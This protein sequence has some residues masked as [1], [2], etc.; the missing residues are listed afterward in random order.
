MSCD[1]VS[2]AISSSFLTR[3]QEGWQQ[4]ADPVMR[5]FG[6]MSPSTYSAIV[7]IACS[8]ILLSS[9]IV[10]RNEGGG[11]RKLAQRDYRPA[12]IIYNG[13][14]FGVHGIGLVLLFF[15]TRKGED[16]FACH[17]NPDSD[18][19]LAIAS[20]MR[21]RTTTTPTTEEG[22]E[23]GVGKEIRMTALK[24]MMLLFLILMI[25]DLGSFMIQVLC[26]QRILITQL[27]HQTIWM[28]IMFTG[29]NVQPIG[30]TTLAAG[31]HM[32]SRSAH[33]ALLLL[34]TTSYLSRRMRCRIMN[35][36]EI[37]ANSVITMHHSYYL[38]TCECGNPFTLSLVDAYCAARTAFLIAS[39]F[40]PT[41][42][43]SFCTI[44]SQRDSLNCHDDKREILTKMQ[45]M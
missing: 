29:L 31:V 16:L 37:I 5:D 12:V 44:C 8:F 25:L 10:S 41:S 34:A 35:A 19:A 36:I 26:R 15:T 11:G 27:M 13:F 17:R 45:E 2:N 38:L 9:K 14:F 21:R 23:D 24:H 3:M 43:S 20:E 4:D 32:A 40:L 30:L 39:A 28:L 18:D 33:H 6:I 42:S 7:L 1:R 22:E